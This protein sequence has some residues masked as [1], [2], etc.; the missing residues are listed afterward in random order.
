MQQRNTEYSFPDMDKKS[1][2]P[3]YIQISEILIDYAQ[4][5][6]LTAGDLLPSENELLAQYDVS[7]NTIRLAV[8]RLVKMNFAVKK[9]GKGTFV[10]QSWPVNLNPIMT[11]EN[12]V[13]ARSFARVSPWR[14]SWSPWPRPGRRTWPGPGT[15]A[16]WSPGS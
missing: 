7:R 4:Q 6:G 9:R 3:I 5:N 16:P 10:K 13:Q 2:T 12:S 15:S 11:L 8:E 14:T 1:Y